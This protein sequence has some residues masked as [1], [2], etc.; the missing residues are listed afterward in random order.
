MRIAAKFIIASIACI[1]IGLT[2]NYLSPAIGGGLAVD[3]LNDSHT[4]S[5]DVK[6]WQ[7]LK[8]N[9]Y[10]FYVLIFIATFGNDVYKSLYM[11]KNK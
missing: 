9:L 2:F 4:A 8:N 1:I 3:Q 7:D 6:M 11:R 10:I 5:A